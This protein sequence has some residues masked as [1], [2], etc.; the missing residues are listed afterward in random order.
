M[1]EKIQY[2]LSVRQGCYQMHSN[3]QPKQYK[4]NISRKS[5]IGIVADSGQ[6]NMKKKSQNRV[7]Q[8]K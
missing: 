6:W 1:H 3:S 8:V 7:Q 5:D 2:T 4:V